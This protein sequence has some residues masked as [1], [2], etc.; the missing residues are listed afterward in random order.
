MHEKTECTVRLP[1]GDSEIYFL[2]QSVREGCPSSPIVF[3]AHHGNGLQEIHEKIE[4]TLIESK[5]GLRCRGWAPE[6]DSVECNCRTSTGK[7][8]RNASC[9]ISTL[10][11]DSCYLTTEVRTCHT[12]SVRQI[13]L[14]QLPRHCRH[15]LH[16]P[17]S[18]HQGT[19][20]WTVDSMTHPRV[21]IPGNLVDGYLRNKDFGSPGWEAS[22]TRTQ[23]YPYNETC[24][25]FG[26]IKSAWLP[27]MWTCV[28]PLL[29]TSRSTLTHAR[30][31]LLLIQIAIAIFEFWCLLIRRSGNWLSKRNW[32]PP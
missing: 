20:T 26:K 13:R 4:G 29:T 9:T 1:V 7:T 25:A 28:Q 10:G 8:A 17:L 22:P 21:Q 27:S 24:L 19:P 31:C 16:V 12:L 14:F 11:A 3:V 32:R 15:R 2:N 5:S 30:H 18:T 23:R 6:G